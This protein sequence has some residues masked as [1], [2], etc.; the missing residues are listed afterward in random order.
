MDTITVKRIVAV[1]A[2]ML[3]AV[4]ASMM[5]V[6]T[7]VG[8]VGTGQPSG[9]AEV[10]ALDKSGTTGGRQNNNPPQ[11]PC[12]QAIAEGRSFPTEREGVRSHLI[13]PAR[14]LLQRKEFRR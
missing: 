12:I 9:S 10:P 14:I 5:L 8:G 11:M 13:P 6:G 4:A 3:L 2:S 7:V 1:M